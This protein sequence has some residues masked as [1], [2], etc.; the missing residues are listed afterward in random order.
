MRATCGV[1]VLESIRLRLVMTTRLR[2]RGGGVFDSWVT[3]FEE[4]FQGASD[5]AAAGLVAE[6]TV[7]GFDGLANLGDGICWGGK[8]VGML[9]TQ[10]G[11]IVEMIAGG[12]DAFGADAEPACDFIQSGAL[13]KRVVAEPCIDI[14]SD[15][16]EVGNGGCECVEEGDDLLGVLVI[17]SDEAERGPGIFVERGVVARFDPFDE[18]GHFGVNGAEKPCV[19]GVTAVVPFVERHV[20]RAFVQVDF[21]FD[22]HEEVGFDLQFGASHDLHQAGHVAAGIDDPLHPLRLQASEQ[23]LEL[24]GYG[25]VLELREQSAIE[26]R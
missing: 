17:T 20:A 10:H 26:V 7:L 1:E 18:A 13:V 5:A 8:P 2:W 16:G 19:L 25:R 6:V 11:E 14:V 9:S 4:K 15:H 21:A 23:E 22:Q 12:E 3:G 24:P